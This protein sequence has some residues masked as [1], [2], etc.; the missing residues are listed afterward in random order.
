M[1]DPL[2]DEKL[3]SLVSEIDSIVPRE[4]GYL[5]FVQYGGGPDESYVT[6]SRLGYLRFGLEF[7]RGSVGEAYPDQP[8]GLPNASINLVNIV[9]A[10][11]DIR[12]DWFEISEGPDKPDQL[13]RKSR[14]R[15][16][17][18][19]CAGILISGVVFAVIGCISI[20]R[21]LLQ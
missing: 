3:R 14:D 13:R 21:W 12:F 5:K 8:G 17:G 6:G 2:S 10:A 4:G 11:S 20:I 15:L 7:L 19:G 16:L 9:D 1:F 18:C